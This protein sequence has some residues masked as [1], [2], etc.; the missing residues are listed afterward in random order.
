VGKRAAFL[1]RVDTG[2]LGSRAGEIFIGCALLGHVVVV[3]CFVEDEEL[4]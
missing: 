4:F 2:G 3:A 1:G